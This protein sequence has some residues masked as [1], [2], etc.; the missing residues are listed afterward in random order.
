MN[1][2]QKITVN[3][4]GATLHAAV[5]FQLQKPCVAHVMS[6]TNFCKLFNYY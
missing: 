1:I 2:A 5:N 6:K 3:S 4:L